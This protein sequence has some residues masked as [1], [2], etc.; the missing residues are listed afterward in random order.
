MGIFL[1][2]MLTVGL[3]GAASTQNKPEVKSSTVKEVCVK[4]KSKKEC[5]LE[6]K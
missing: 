4:H 5:R 3:L 2:L 6:Y 1:I